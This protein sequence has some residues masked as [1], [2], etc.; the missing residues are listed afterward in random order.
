MKIIFE[1]EIYEIKIV[2]IVQGAIVF[3]EVITSYV[4]QVDPYEQDDH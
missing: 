4:G 3:E 1:N 2:K